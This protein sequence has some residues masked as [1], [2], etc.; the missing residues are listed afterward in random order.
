MAGVSSL[1]K[2]QGFLD[3]AGILCS[4]ACA[5]HCAL[6]PILA[7]LAPTLTVQFESEWVHLLLL[8]L[9]LPISGTAF[10]RLK[11]KHG[12]NLPM[13]LGI[14]GGL[15][16]LLAVLTEKIAALDIHGLELI[17]T[18]TGSVVLIVGHLLNL[19][20]LKR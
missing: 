6:T 15:L 4:G 9:I 11:K 3:R 14:V 19:R 5:I 13:I 20:E 7:L 16:L 2:N 8:L 12:Q 17:L 1:V 10:Y 18:V